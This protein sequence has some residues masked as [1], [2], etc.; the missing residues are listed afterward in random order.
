[1]A[2]KIFRF[3]YQQHLFKVNNCMTY[4]GAKL[5]TNKYKQKPDRC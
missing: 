3:I 4:M 5:L 2:T 1:M